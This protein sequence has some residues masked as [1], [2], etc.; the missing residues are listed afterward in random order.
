MI[1]TV[2]AIKVLLM[3]TARKNEILTG[4]WSK[5]DW[6]RQI[7]FQPK[8][9]TGWKPIY[10]NDTAIKILKKL[11][12]RPEREM[13]DY[14]FKGKGY[15]SHLKSVKTAWGTMLKTPALKIIASTIYAIREQVFALK[16]ANLYILSAKCLDIRAKEQQNATLTFLKTNPE[17]NRASG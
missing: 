3:T 12:E 11:Y 13:N 5:L 6:E 15:K 17:S 1:Y 2:S 7:L 8:S 10:L 9:K 14:I 4:Q 16:T